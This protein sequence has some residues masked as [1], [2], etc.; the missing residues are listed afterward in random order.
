MADKV[1]K[2]N[3]WVQ[4]K[5]TEDQY[6]YSHEKRCSGQ[7]VAFLGF[8][9][10]E[11]SSDPMV[12]CRQEYTPAWVPEAQREAGERPLLTSCFTGG[13][14]PGESPD[15]AV[16]REALEEAG[17]QVDAVDFVS[18]GEIRSTKSSDTVYSLYAVNLTDEQGFSEKTK[19]DGSDAD[20]EAQNVLMSVSE[21]LE[22]ISDPVGL[23]ILAKVLLQDRE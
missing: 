12:L 2:D 4:L 15:E 17:I 7:I 21:A 13:V 5:E 8:Y 14:D 23:A 9:F 19:G 18:L 6:V 10:P 3:P 1:L 20:A 22:K 16:Y 11:G